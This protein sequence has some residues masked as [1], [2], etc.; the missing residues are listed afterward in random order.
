MKN[1]WKYIKI[2]VTVVV[3]IFFV[4]YFT[5]N[6]DDFFLVLSTPLKYIITIAISFSALVFLNCIFT[7][8]ILKSF[9]KR[10]SVIESFYITVVS[11]LGNYFLPMRGGAVIRSVYLKKRLEVSYSQFISTL[12]GYYIIVFLVYSFFALMA[13]VIIHFKY[14]IVSIPLY[15]FF[16]VL[17]LFMIV[18]SLVKFPVE[19]IKEV[20]YGFVNKIVNIIKEILKGWNLIVEN[21]R[22][23]I[24]LIFTTL[25]TFVVHTVLFFME[26]KAM[27]IDSNFIKVALY[28]CLSAVSLLIS[29]TPGSLGIREGIFVITS[30]ILGISNDQ[31]MQ[32]ALLDRGSMIISL[33]ILFSLSV[34][35]R[36]LKKYFLDENSS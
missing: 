4:R 32:L 30:N 27:G 3:I 34:I 18:L 20:K 31:I 11:N 15:I 1:F 19:K 10:I 7:K 2:L 8:I 36:N 25:S 14:G 13:L 28:N 26:F 16:G 29:F 23:L 24:S 5:I 35:I 17:F 12:Y 9:D 33:V 22:L 21:K 6:K